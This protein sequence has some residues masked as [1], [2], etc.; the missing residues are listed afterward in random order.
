MKLGTFTKQPGERLSKSI[1]YDDA[2]DEGDEISAVMSCTT[3]PVGL[4]VVPTLVSGERVRLWV[5]KGADGTAYKIEVQV[6]T[7][8]G[9]I[10]EDELVCRVREV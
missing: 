6:Q 9:E 2:L 1:R 10:F 3:S 4:S 5:E 7:A 8:G